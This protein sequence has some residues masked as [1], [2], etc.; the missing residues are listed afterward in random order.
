MVGH[1]GLAG[2]V[3]VW[4]ADPGALSP[5]LDVA[6]EQS[7]HE[8]RAVRIDRVRVHG[9]HVL[10]R[11]AGVDS[12]EDARSLRGARILGARARLPKVKGSTYREVDLVGMIVR[13]ESLGS[14]G[15]V[16]RVQ[17]YPSCDMLVVG[18]RHLMIPMLKAYDVVV[19]LAAR[20]IRVKLPAG[21][22]EL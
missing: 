16:R 5:G 6:L 4:P 10:V 11:F 22:E 1:F 21:F 20:E 19:D 17:K 9:G 8:P 18:G 15:E 14:L 2:E 3:K 12:A 13:D 7:G